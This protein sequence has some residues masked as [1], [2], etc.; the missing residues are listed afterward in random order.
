MFRCK[1]S[2]IIDK[3]KSSET[4]S[5]EITIEEV[6]KIKYQ[7]KTQLNQIAEK[8][9]IDFNFYLKKQKPY[10]DFDQLKNLTAKGFGISAHSWDHPLYCELKLED[11]LENTIKSL[12]FAKENNFLDDSFAFPFTDFGVQKKFFESL[13][14]NKQISYSFGCAGIKIDSFSKNLQRIPMETGESAVQTLKK[15]IAYYKFKKLLN[16]NTII[17]K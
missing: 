4:K 10:L 17:R 2:L 1:E 12:N 6:L 13:F 7:D 8:L 3:I 16:K 15:E 14:K 11:Q 9:E 5:L